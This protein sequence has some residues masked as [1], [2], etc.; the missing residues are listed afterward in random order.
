MLGHE[1]ILMHD[2]KFYVW[3][4]MISLGITQIPESHIMKRWTRDAYRDMPDHLKMYQKDNPSMKSRTFLHSALYRTAIDMV[5]MGDTNRESYEVAMTHMLNAMPILA[6]IS[7][8]KDGPGLEERVHAADGLSSDQ[9][10][11]NI[12]NSLRPDMVAPPRRNYL[13]C[14]TTARTKPGWQVSVPRTKFC[15]IC[16]NRGHRAPGCPA[17][18]DNAKKPR[19]EAHC[20]NCG[21]A[22]HKNNNCFTI[23]Q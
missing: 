16:H 11:I 19:R 15:T 13:G 20:S 9:G 2:I 7:K 8:I 17:N 4:V 22:G 3:Q 12:C 10:D 5:H 23:N 14:P 18:F 6:K 21:L 1:E